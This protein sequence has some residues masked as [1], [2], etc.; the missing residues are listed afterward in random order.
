MKV[1]LQTCVLEN[2]R[3]VNWGLSGGSCVRR[4]GSEDPH[5][6]ERKF[7]FLVLVVLVTAVVLADLNIWL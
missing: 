5:Q 4:P 3:Y 1:I 7:S 2:F 6:H